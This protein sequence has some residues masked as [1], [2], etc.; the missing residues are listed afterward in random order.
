MVQLALAAL[1]IAVVHSFIK[2]AARAG[3]REAAREDDAGS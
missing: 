1:G 3:A 2:S